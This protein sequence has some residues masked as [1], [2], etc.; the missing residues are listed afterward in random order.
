MPEEAERVR[1]LAAR[2]PRVHM[3]PGLQPAE[4]AG[5]L[6][7]ADLFVNPSKA[8]AVPL[9]VQETMCAGTPWLATPECGAVHDWAGGVI[10]PLEDFGPAIDHLLA[11]PETLR[12]LGAA[13]RAHWEA[14][15]HYG[16]AAECY[17]ALLRG[18]RT[19]PEFP[20]PADAL[21][22]TDRVRDEV[23]EAL[24]APA[25]PLAALDAVPA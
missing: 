13:G 6:R 17:D 4:V 8:E 12:A 9:I 3:I 10:L 11:Q 7:E 25:A 14:C 22:L 20:A 16:V 18:S 19:V 21:A 23:Y 5:A 1:A 15:F 24:V 2:D